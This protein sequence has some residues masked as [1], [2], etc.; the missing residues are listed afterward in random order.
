M[1]L[2]LPPLLSLNGGYVDTAGYLALHGLF[3]AHVTGNFVTLGAALVQDNSGT[4]GKLLALPVF[5][6][7]VTA[8]RLFSYGLARRGLPAL[9]TLLIIKFLLL[10]AGAILALELGPF[11]EGN[12]W[13]GVLTGMVLVCAMAIQNAAHRIHMTTAPPT[14][15]MT[16][17]TTQIMIDLA[18]LLHGVGPEQSAA[19]KLRLSKM[20]IAVT[21]FAIG[22][23]AAALCFSRFGEWCF[24]IPPALAAIAVILPPP[25]SDTKAHA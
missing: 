17:T 14:T 4:L 22:C 21:A 18:D 24:I 8:S 9:R 10:L 1:K 2:T 3:T 25:A 16:G 7:V 23:A 15:L 13:P 11:P 5:C 19:A 6:A 12:A 20:S